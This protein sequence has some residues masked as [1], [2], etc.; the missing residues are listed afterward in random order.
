MG[1]NPILRQEDH[2]RSGIKLPSQQIFVLII[3]W[4]S[5]ITQK[6]SFV[7]KLFI[8]RQMRI[9]FLIC[10]ELNADDRLGQC[11]C[12]LIEKMVKPKDERIVLT[13]VIKQLTTLLPAER[14]I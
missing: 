2:I 14:K 7:S 1:C 9:L 3:Q 6:V 4:F 10:P 5:I 12:T 13:E 8:L 11:L